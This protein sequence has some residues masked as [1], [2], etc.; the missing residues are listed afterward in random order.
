MD[1]DTERIISQ[2]QRL[3]YHDGCGWCAEDGMSWP[4]P[5]IRVVQPELI[6][7]RRE[8]TP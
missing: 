1:E 2:I 6:E 5:T 4:C 3:H 8:K 7:A